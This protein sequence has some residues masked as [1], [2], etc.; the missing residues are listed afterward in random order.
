MTEEQRPIRLA[1][2]GG[3]STGKT[4]FISRLTLNIVH[5]SHYPTRDQTNWLFDYIPHSKLAKTI[6][7]G[8]AHERLLRRTPNSQRLEPIFKS[9]LVSPNVLLS[10]LV[11]Q[12]FIDNYTSMKTQ[13]KN[14]TNSSNFFMKNLDIKKTNSNNDNGSDK[15]LQVRYLSS[16]NASQLSLSSQ[17]QQALTQSEDEESNIPSNYIPPSY[18]PIPIDIIDTPGFNPQMVVPFLEVS[19]FRNLD[20]SILKGLAN[21]PRQPVSTRT[22]LVASGASELNGKIDGYILVYSAIPEVSHHSLSLPPE[23]SNELESN[24]VRTSEEEDPSKGSSDESN[25]GGFQILLNIRSCILDAWAE[26][27]NYKEAWEKGKEDDIYSLLHNFKNIWKSQESE[28]T[29]NSKIKDLRTFKTILPEIDLN[30]ASPTSPP[31]CIIVCTH[32][33][34]PL[35]SPVLIK[36]GRDLATQWNCGFIGVNNINDF[37]VDVAL[38]LIIKEIVE[39]EKLLSQRRKST[40]ESNNEYVNDNMFTN[41]IKN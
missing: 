10:P 7:D 2:L 36:R 37:N 26:Y 16:P 12:A 31:P 4:S 41:L 34:E 19:L 32:V 35:A 25:A 14:K 13:S 27:V 20:K 1:V 29:K 33:N 6:L 9:P 15:N 30:P 40:T 38:S 24:E 22:L 3:E 28:S 8:Q 11:F 39:K 21:E 23:Y 17:S 5:E 18:S